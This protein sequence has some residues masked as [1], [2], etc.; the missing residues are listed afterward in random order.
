MEK[1]D[2]LK[3]KNL[4]IFALAFQLKKKLMRKKYYFF[5]QQYLESINY[6]YTR[7]VL[8]LLYVKFW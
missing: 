2:E 8:K 5:L 7:H 6:L 1:N 4:I 3:K